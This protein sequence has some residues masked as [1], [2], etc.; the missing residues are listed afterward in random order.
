MESKSPCVG[1]HSNRHDV[2]S[3]NPGSKFR[4]GAKS[5]F[6]KSIDRKK[7]FFNPSIFLKEVKN[8]TRIDRGIERFGGDIRDLLFK[9]SRMTTNGPHFYWDLN[10]ILPFKVLTW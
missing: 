7:V 4:Q 8:A 3:P 2:G 5:R 1:G 10:F 9:W 6:K